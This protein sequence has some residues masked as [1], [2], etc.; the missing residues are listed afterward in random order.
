MRRVIFVTTGMLALVGL[1]G[2]KEEPIVDGFARV[3]ILDAPVAVLANLDTFYV[4]RVKADEG[5]FPDSVVC[6]IREG[7]DL[8]RF[9]LLDDGGTDSLWGP[10]FAS[11]R[12][13]DIAPHNG[14]YTRGVNFHTLTGGT[15]ADYVF[16]FMSYT[17]GGPDGIVGPEIAVRARVPEE[18]LLTAWPQDYRFDECFA[19]I[20]MQIRV[21]RDTSDHVDSVWMKVQQEEGSSPFANTLL[22]EP[23]VG[24]TVWQRQFDPTAFE[25]AESC[26]PAFY[27]LHYFAKTHFGLTAEQSVPVA[28]FFNQPP[29]LANPIMPDTAYRPSYPGEV[30][31][32]SVTVDLHDCELAGEIYYYGIHFDR[33]RDDTLHWSSDPTFFLRDDGLAGD[34]TA[35]DGRYTVDLT[36]TPSDTLLNNL[37]YFRFYAVDCA[38]PYLQSPYLLDSLRVIQL[39]GGAGIHTAGDDFGMGIV[40][41]G[42]R[43]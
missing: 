3:S 12:S 22:F 14:T 33:S 24:D 16:S 13:G 28:S 23:V 41:Q 20:N 29:T 9:A 5:Y 4:Y 39:F 25:C 40:S 32:I 34:V 43:P 8:W 31:T 6:M 37:Y 30:D 38:P 36:I 10:D 21:S 42:F 19:P 27:T 35:G 18:C 2:C 1:W 17:R 15:A 26:P 11:A 7:N